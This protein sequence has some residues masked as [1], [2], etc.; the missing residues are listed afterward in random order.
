MI[1]PIHDPAFDPSCATGTSAFRA[2]AGVDLGIQD[3]R[4]GFG[5][6]FATER[7]FVESIPVSMAGTAGAVYGATADKPHV[8]PAAGTDPG[9]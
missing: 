6:R 4:G 7:H 5:S 1:R 8:G 3:G 2:A 9:G